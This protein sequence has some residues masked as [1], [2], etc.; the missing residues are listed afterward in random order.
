MATRTLNTPRLPDPFFVVTEMML[1]PLPSILTSETPNNRLA[2]P[3]CSLA[4]IRRTPV[5]FATVNTA[6]PVF[7]VM[8]LWL[9]IR[10][11]GISVVEHGNTGLGETLG[12]GDGDGV[13]VAVGLGLALPLPLL[14]LLPL[15]PPLPLPFP[16]GVAVGVGVGSIG[17]IGSTGFGV[18]VA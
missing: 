14:P 8:L 15:L 2:P 4:L 13:G 18:G 17:S 11:E 10:D 1:E 5:P 6:V 9:K 7:W 3:P 12:D 16:C